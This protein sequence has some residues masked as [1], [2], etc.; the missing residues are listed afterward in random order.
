MPRSPSSWVSPRRQSRHTSVER[1]R[2]FATRSGWWPMTDIED[3][4]R[5]YT[6]AV[7]ASQRPVA[8]GEVVARPR[9]GGSRRI[10][11]AIAV[12]LV[13]VCGIAAAVLRVNSDSE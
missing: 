9:R 2:A 3:Q 10:G 6:D 8:L 7:T 1:S 13:L 5:A 11:I 4:L 12:V